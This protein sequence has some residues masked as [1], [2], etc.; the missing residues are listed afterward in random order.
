MTGEY[1]RRLVQIFRETDEWI[2]QR[3]AASGSATDGELPDVTFAENSIA[4]AG[5]LKTTSDAYIY[6]DPAEIEALRTYCYAYGMEPVAIGRFKRTS[7]AIVGTELSPKAYYVWRP[8]EMDR[9][10]AGTYRGDPADGNWAAKIADPDGDAEG[11][12]PEELS[13]FLLRHGLQSKLSSPI[14]APPNGGDDGD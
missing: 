4:F 6:I 7:P 9:T 13:A 1:E 5:E 14:T 11:I 8:G 3:A 2:A 10:D 12:L